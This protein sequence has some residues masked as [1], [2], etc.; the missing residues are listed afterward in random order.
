MNDATANNCRELLYLLKAPTPLRDDLIGSASERI[1][2]TFCECVLNIV[3]EQ[4]TLSPEEKQTFKQHK[5]ICLKI[6][7][8]TKNYKRKR[9][10]LAS[11]S[12]DLLRAFV[13]AIEKNV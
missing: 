12:S 11:L 6:S 4:V 13:S 2:N 1:V 8:P 10:L 7:K 3:Y 5:K 9:A